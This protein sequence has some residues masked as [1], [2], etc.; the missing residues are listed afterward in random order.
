LLTGKEAKFIHFIHL[1]KIAEKVN[2]IALMQRNHIEDS[3]SQ[4]IKKNDFFSQMDKPEKYKFKKSPQD[5]F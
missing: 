3:I 5:S 4:F 1:F 2:N